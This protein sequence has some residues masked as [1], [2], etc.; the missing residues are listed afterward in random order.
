MLVFIKLHKNNCVSPLI[1]YLIGKR[2]LCI[3]GDNVRV[4]FP[5]IMCNEMQWCDNHLVLID[6]PLTGAFKRYCV[7]CNLK[8]PY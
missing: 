5:C 3:K 1:Y 6:D 4:E 7:E 8:K 2:S